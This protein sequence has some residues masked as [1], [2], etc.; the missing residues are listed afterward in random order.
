MFLTKLCCRRCLRAEQE[1]SAAA[2]ENGAGGDCVSVFTDDDRQGIRR[3]CMLP[4]QSVSAFSI[5]ET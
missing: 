5:N 3:R 2:E 4:S 1:N